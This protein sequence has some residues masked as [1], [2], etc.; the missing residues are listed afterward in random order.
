MEQKFFEPMEY[1]VVDVFLDSLSEDRRG[2]FI[3][4][5]DK[6]YGIVCIPEHE[7]A[8]HWVPMVVKIEDITFIDDEDRDINEE[9]HEE[10]WDREFRKN[11]FDMISSS[12]EEKQGY[13]CKG[14]VYYVAEN[15]FCNLFRGEIQ[16][17]QR[18]PQ[19]LYFFRG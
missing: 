5:L 6:V 4:Y 7:D 16:Y 14:C 12:I 3:Q 10:D 18:F 11:I 15:P 9:E 17:G 2:V 19:C 1:P 8:N 13:Y